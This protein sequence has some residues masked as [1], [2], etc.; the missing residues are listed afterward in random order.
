MLPL[1]LERH[2]RCIRSLQ[3]AD[4]IVQLLSTRIRLEV[5]FHLR[6]QVEVL[7]GHR[8]SIESRLGHQLGYRML[9]RHHDDSLSETQELAEPE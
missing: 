8:C 5:G 6:P 9:I 7:K 2:A 3:Q 4:Q 1:H